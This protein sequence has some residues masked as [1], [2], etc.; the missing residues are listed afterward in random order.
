MRPNALKREISKTQLL[1]ISFAA[2]FGSGWL[3][4]PLYAAQMAGPFALLAWA[5]GAVIS[6]VIG[7]TMAEVVVLYPKSGGLSTIA[8]ETH[9]SFLSLLL[10]IFN[11]VVFIILPAIE[12]RAVLQYFSSFMK[13]SFLPSG[14]GQVGQSGLAF[15]LLTLVT[16]VNLYGAKVTA[17]I[18]QGVVFF[19]L[20]TPVLICFAFS[21][22][23]GFDRMID[24][25]HLGLAPGEAGAIPWTQIFQAIATSGIIFSFNGFNQ[26]T[27][28]AGEAKNPQKAIPFAILG[29]LLISGLLYFAI[30]YVF[31]MAVPTESL[32]GGWQNLSFPGDD[33]PFAGLAVALGLG[34]ILSIIYLDS[35]LSPLGTAFTYA[36]AAPRL[37]FSLTEGSTIEIPGL[38]LNRHGISP[39]ALAIT[40]VLECLAFVLLPN[41]KAM[42]ALLVAAFVLGYTVA[43][44]SLLVLRKIRPELPRPFRVKWAPF[45]CYLS[46]LFS[47]LMVFSCGWIALR[48]LMVFSGFFLVIYLIFLAKREIRNDIYSIVKGSG[49]FLFQIFSLGALSFH[50]T[51]STMDFKTILAWVAFI[52]LLALIFATVTRPNP[53]IRSA[54]SPRGSTRQVVAQSE[55]KK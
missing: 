13:T 12:V 35:V 22:T 14:L 17:K 51:Q 23:L 24:S 47:N 55:G 1:L 8:Q 48:N 43:P 38:K 36:S 11:L 16:L 52:S 20:M 44:A 9:G 18:T 49:W 40:L 4:S 26:A 50:Q 15:C 54:P 3:F 28:F 6:I 5:L 39:A 10:T 33:G 25:S 45:F 27:L 30:Q 29:S 41:L 19:K 7:I 53:R 34:G 2:I 37:L 21:Y 31:I 42:I 32:A 46:I